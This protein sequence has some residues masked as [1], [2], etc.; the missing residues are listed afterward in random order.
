[1][2]GSKGQMGSTVLDQ[3]TNMLKA[4]MLNAQPIRQAMIQKF[5]KEKNYGELTKF[6]YKGQKNSR[7][8][9]CNEP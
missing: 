2:L 5:L 3:S 1:L 6:I 9:S 8:K 4:Y 7:R